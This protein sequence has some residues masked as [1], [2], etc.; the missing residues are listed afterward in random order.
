MSE[1]FTR[2]VRNIGSAEARAETR[3]GHM[4][5]RATDPVVTIADVRW[6]SDLESGF[7]VAGN[8]TRPKAL[9]R[10]FR[11]LMPGPP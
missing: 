8:A 1:I 7:P 2:L 4:G 9:I 11:P 6:Y 3:S 5:Q 10:N